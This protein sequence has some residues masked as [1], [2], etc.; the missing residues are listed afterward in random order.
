MGFFIDPDVMSDEQLLWAFVSYGYVLFS[1]A[2]LIGDGSELLFLIPSMANLV[3]SVVLPVLG[4]V[5]DGMMVL[6]SGMGPDAQNQVSVGVGALAGSTIMLLTATW[7]MAMVGGRVDIVDGQAQY[8]STEKLT[9]NVGF[10]ST[11]VAVL[12]QIG[13]NAYLMLG[14]TLLYLVIQIPASIAEKATHKTDEQAASENLYALIGFVLCVVCFLYY[15]YAN[16]VKA[17]EPEGSLEQKQIN[18]IIQAINSGKMTVVA[19]LSEFWAENNAKS[20]GNRSLLDALNDDQRRKLKTIIKPFFQFY[21]KNND[22]TIDY[23]E[24]CMLLKDM[25]VQ[26][27]KEEMQRLFQLADTDASG[28]MNFE[29]FADCIATCS[30]NIHRGKKTITKGIGQE[31]TS[32]LEADDGDDDE[33][34][35]EE[36]IPEDL[37]NL[38]PDVQQRRIF[39]RACQMMG[40]GTIL[41]LIFSD[42]MVDVL[43]EIGVRTDIPPFYISFVLA[44]L[45]SNASELL[46]SYNYAAKRTSKTMTTSLV[47]LEGAA[48]MN[49]TFCLAIF[50]AL[51]YFRGLA[52]QFT[53]ETISIVL[54]Q[55]IMGAVALTGSTMT[56]KTGCFIVCLYPLSLIGVYLLENKMGFD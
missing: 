49:N 15:L 1:G 12:P 23:Q 37:A 50:Y 54:V 48:C 35:E 9:G 4:A 5:P 2:G 40:M 10:F 3:G 44:P 26:V 51:I 14:T 36:D 46:A 56:M 34:D 53:A 17:N 20:D 31:R 22:K 52:W 27:A 6:F 19:V 7:F 39:Q 32:S 38:P 41:V 13:E 21:D 28:Y 16:Y 47:Q 29:E 25:R 11:G 8:K 45:A 43:A 30:N 24:F 55:F 42:P 18:N 33:E